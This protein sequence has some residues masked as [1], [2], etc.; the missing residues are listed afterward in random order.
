MAS[1]LVPVHSCL[2]TAFGSSRLLRRVDSG[3]TCDV[4]CA[5][6]APIMQ[7]VATGGDDGSLQVRRLDA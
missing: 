6:F 2:H 4:T 1:A 5:A 7:L 3:H